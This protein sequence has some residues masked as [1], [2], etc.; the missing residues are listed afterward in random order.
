MKIAILGTRGIPNHYGGFEKYAELFAAFLANKGWNVTVYNSH[1]HPFQSTDYK[2]VTIKHIYDPETKMGTVGQF[3]YDLNCILDIRKQNFDLVYQLGYTSSAIFNFLF[4]KQTTIVTNMDGMEWKRSKYNK[5]VQRFLMYSEKIAVKR[6]DFLVADSFGIKEYLDKK[7]KTNSFYSAYTAQ[8]PIGYSADLL[9]PYLLVPKQYN[10]L[11]ARMEPENNIDI[12]L[13]AHT[14]NNMNFPIV[15]IG[16]IENHYGQMMVKKYAQFPHVKFI[17]GVYQMETLDS[18]RHYA[19]MYFH[20]H[21][22][23]GTNPSLLE[24]MACS[25]PILA[26]NNIFNRSVLGQNALFFDN[27]TMLY[28]Q[29]NEFE[30]QT[31]FFNHA[32]EANL[33]KICTVFSEASIFETLKEKLIDWQLLKKNDVLTI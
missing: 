4:P 3:I 14:I 30:I 31:A 25:C 7:Y 6:S 16:K 2:G 23:G 9:K 17:G 13:E 29:I 32:I 12:I 10:L 20:G 26:H 28:Q 18:I 1:N 27:A 19:K 33:E 22:V 24:A 11:V 15:V 5:Y 21:S 8:V